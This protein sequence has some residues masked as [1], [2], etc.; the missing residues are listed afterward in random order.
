MKL[1]HWA[2]S[3]V[4]LIVVLAAGLA[5]AISADLAWLKVATLVVVVGGSAALAM[6]AKRNR[7]RNEPAGDD[8]HR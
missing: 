1:W 6:V 2:V 7:E 8:Q 4:A 5:V 3:Q